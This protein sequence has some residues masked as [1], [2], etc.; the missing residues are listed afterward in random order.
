MEIIKNSDLRL[1]K[2]VLK[3]NHIDLVK[4]CTDLIRLKKVITICGPTCTGKSKIGTITAKLINTDIISIDSMQVYR[5]MDIGTAKYDSKRYGVKQFMTNI[6]EPDH[7]LSV[8]EFKDMCR[9]IIKKEF[10]R[11]NK[12]PLMV[13]GSGMYMRGV[14]KNM[15]IVPDGSEMIRK[16]LKENIKR[17]GIKEYYKKLKKIDKDYARKVS[18]NDHRRIIRAL[19]VY[20]I[21][22]TPFSRFQ[23]VWKKKSP[24]YDS[25]LI[26]LE[27]EKP[28]LNELIKKRVRRMFEIGLVEEVKNLVKKGYKN[29]TS[30]LQAVG[31]KEVIKYLDGEISFNECIEKVDRNTRKLAKK[32][33]TWFRSE[34]KINWIRVSNYDN[35]FNLILDIFKV[36]EM[37]TLN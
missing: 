3:N 17:K 18:E 16:R 20:E 31:Y 19:E 34:L 5:G 28:M 22:G 25:V 30:M 15:D 14:L 33:M 36:L 9:D 32:Q 29:C 23:N 24:E 27:M 4:L 10:F 6:F 1:I 21:T 8:L 35:I 11:K 37:S 7:S 12:I 2:S 13:G 26:G